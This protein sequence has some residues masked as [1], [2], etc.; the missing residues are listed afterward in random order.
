MSITENAA[1]FIA[2][3]KLGG[4]AVPCMTAIT[5]QSLQHLHSPLMPHP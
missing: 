4:W 5:G 3:L 2:S 1:V